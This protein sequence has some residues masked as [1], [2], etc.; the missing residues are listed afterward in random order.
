MSR[1]AKTEEEARQVKAA[2]PGYIAVRELA[3]TALTTMA[4][5]L[6]LDLRE[7]DARD[8]ATAVVDAIHKAAELR[9]IAFACDVADMEVAAN[10]RWLLP[11]ARKK[12]ETD[13]DYRGV[14]A[15]LEQFAEGAEKVR[16]ELVERLARVGRE[17]LAE[18]SVAVVA[19]PAPAEAS[20][21]ARVAA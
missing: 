20:A 1:N 11:S 15:H 6:A 21:E 16:N 7:R 12:A 4:E 8:L 5:D 14:V 13:P 10:E 2:L 17:W 9:G 19:L 3:T 18:R